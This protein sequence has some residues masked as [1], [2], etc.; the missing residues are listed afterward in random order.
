[1]QLNENY[2]IVYNKDN[3]ILQFFEQRE[4]NIVTKVIDEVSGKNKQISTPSGEY[5]EFTE[6]YYY[7]SLQSALTEFLR[8]CTWGTE[9]AKEVLSKLNELE[10]LIKTIK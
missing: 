7:P 9:T 2:R 3:T 1:M 4:K 10:G 8:Q 5:A 6:N